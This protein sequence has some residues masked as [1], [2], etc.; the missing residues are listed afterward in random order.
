MAV[1]CCV[2]PLAI[3]GFAGATAIETRAAGP[4][5]E[6]WQY[7]EPASEKVLPIEGTNCQS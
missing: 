1:N 5:V 6:E 3:V 2:V 7:P 4:T